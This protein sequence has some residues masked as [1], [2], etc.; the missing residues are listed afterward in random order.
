VIPVGVSRAGYVLVGGLSSRMG[1]DKALL[2]FR[3]TMLGKH[4][5]DTV[6]AAAGKVNLVGD[7]E[8]YRFL[9]YP[10]LA[11]RYPAEGPL[12]GTLTALAHATEDWNLILACDMPAVSREFLISLFEAAANA[13]ADVLAPA[14]PAGRPE[15]LCAVYHRRVLQRFEDVF[16]QGERKMSLALAAARTVILQVSATDRFEN[17]NTPADWAAYAPH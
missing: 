16:A 1:R 4:V 9:G 2:P 3:G 15:P 14:S 6:L 8:R 5:A 17:V 12:G 11:D 7:P 13:G 10:V